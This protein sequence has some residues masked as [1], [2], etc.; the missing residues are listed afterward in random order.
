MRKLNVSSFVLF[1]HSCW[2]FL[3]GEHLNQ[4]P[5]LSS[6]FF[7]G[8]YNKHISQKIA[9]I[10]GKTKLSMLIFCLC[11]YCF[12]ICSFNFFF[13]LC[14]S[15]YISIYHY[16]FVFIC[17]SGFIYESSRHV[18]FSFFEELS[19]EDIQKERKV[20]IRT[21]WVFLSSCVCLA[22]GFLCFWA[23]WLTVDVNDNQPRGLVLR[24]SDLIGLCC[25]GIGII[26]VCSQLKLSMRKV[27]YLCAKVRRTH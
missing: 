2:N 13:N 19:W 8:F 20:I 15:P 5:E 18:F 24:C 23:L 7:D 11:G 16:I 1:F 3:T 12:W 4:T 22:G 14:I 21:G 26:L 17:Y 27:Q 6:S 10:Q 9:R 25:Q